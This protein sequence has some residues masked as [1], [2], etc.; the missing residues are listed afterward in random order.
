[1]LWDIGKQ[2]RPR[3]DDA[4][5]C[6][7]SGSTLFMSNTG[8]STKLGNNEN[9]KDTLYIGNRPFQRLM[10]KEPTLHK[11]VNIVKPLQNATSFVGY[12]RE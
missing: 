4:E 7:R 10:V 3:S 9:P 8:I 5:R 12:N 11:R 1:M 6:V 2:C